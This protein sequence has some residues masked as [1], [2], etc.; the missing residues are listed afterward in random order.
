MWER[1]EGRQLLRERAEAER[2]RAERRAEEEATREAGRLRLQELAAKGGLRINVGSG[3]LTLKG[4]TNVDIQCDWDDMVFMDVT[5]PWPLPDASVDAINSEHF[6]EHIGLGETRRYFAEAARVLREGGVIRT[7]T[8]SLSG[9]VD[10]YLAGDPEILA[11]Y[12]ERIVGWC[13]ARNHSEMLNNTFFEWGHRHIYDVEALTELLEDA[14]FVEIERAEFGRSRHSQLTGIDTHDD[15]ES[16][17]DLVF[18]LD[19]VKP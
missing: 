17:R 5:E 9:A 14:G 12:Q 3:P 2:R 18:A 7:S 16:L 19:A 10:A 4:W 13:E 6:I 1:A 11:K 15:G 8:P